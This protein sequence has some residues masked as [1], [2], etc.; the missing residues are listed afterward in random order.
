VNGYYFQNGK[1]KPN[2][3]GRYHTLGFFMVKLRGCFKSKPQN[4][5]EDMDELVNNIDTSPLAGKRA[6][7]MLE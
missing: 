7:K 6:L 3:A 4:S 2:N 5:I 1:E